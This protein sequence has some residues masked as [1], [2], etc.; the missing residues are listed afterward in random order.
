MKES[1]T[2]S[3]ID[4]LNGDKILRKNRRLYT[5]EL[6]KLS[7]EECKKYVDSI[8]NNDRKEREEI[9]YSFKRS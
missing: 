1:N 5:E 9:A 8:Y 3:V 2:K 6:F 7:K 4:I